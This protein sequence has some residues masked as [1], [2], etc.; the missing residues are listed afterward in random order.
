MSQSSVF[1]E[2][3]YNKIVDK[4]RRYSARLS[5]C[6]WTHFSSKDDLHS[7]KIIGANSVSTGMFNSI[8]K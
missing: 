4:L 6:P 7:S 1:N 8:K 2:K 3:L 5:N